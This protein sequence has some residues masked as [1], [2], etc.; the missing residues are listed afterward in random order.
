ML[1]TPH[2]WRQLNPSN[3]VTQ[4]IVADDHKS[5]ISS[6]LTPHRTLICLALARF[7]TYSYLWVFNSLSLLCPTVLSYDWQ[8]GSVPL[9]TSLADPR[10]LHILAATLLLLLLV[11]LVLSTADR[12]QG[13]SHLLCYCQDASYNLC[14]YCRQL[15]ECQLCLVAG[16]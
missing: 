15:W 8:L 11:K 13:H 14:V 5:S 7:L 12:S 10:V 3:I 4:E 6:G 9:L 2:S 1:F 16:L